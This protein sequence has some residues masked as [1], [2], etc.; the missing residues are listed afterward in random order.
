MSGPPVRDQK[1]APSQRTGSPPAS[2]FAVFL[3][4]STPTL[5]SP[6]SHHTDLLYC[7]DEELYRFSVQWSI[8]G[9]VRGRVPGRVRT[10][11]GTRPGRV[12]DA[13]RMLLPEPAGAGRGT[14]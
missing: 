12:R 2:I 3:C 13:C 4:T 9:R 8:L 5:L 6:A 7:C 1:F 10:D 14:G 11:P